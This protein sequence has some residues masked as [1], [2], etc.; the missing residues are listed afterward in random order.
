MKPTTLFAALLGIAIGAGGAIYYAKNVP[1]PAAN[2]PV[3][4]PSTIGSA[5]TLTLGQSSSGEL[6]SK[7]FLNLSDGVRSSLFDVKA[8]AGQIIKIIVSG[9]LRP[10]ISVLRNG[11]LVYTH[12]ALRRLPG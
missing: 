10:Q 5:Q 9:P 7:S 12:S 6:T 8:E 4:A 2:S 1:T 3:S 11:E